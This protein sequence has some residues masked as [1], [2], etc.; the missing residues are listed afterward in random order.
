MRNAVRARGAAALLPGA[1]A[2]TAIAVT[3][4]AVSA[5]SMPLA[6]GARAQSPS[7]DC[8][9]TLTEQ[10]GATEFSDVNDRFR[11]SRRSVYLDAKLESGKTVRMR[12]MF[13]E[14]GVSEVQVYEEPEMGASRDWPTWGPADEYRVEQEEAAAEPESGTGDTEQAAAP[15]EP[16]EGTPSE[17]PAEQPADQPADGSPEEPADAPA[18]QPAE[19]QEPQFGVIKKAP[20]N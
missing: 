1:I 10:Y 20:T 8:T 17:Q 7:E 9:K 13:R 16:G 14:G 11:N 5:L 4:I 19:E 3:T 6:T 15:A 18:E 2:V 12:C